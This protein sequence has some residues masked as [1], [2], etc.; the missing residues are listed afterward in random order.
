MKFLPSLTLNEIRH[1]PRG[2]E[3][4]PVTQSF[5]ACFQALAQLRQLNWLQAGFATRPP[6]LHQCF[7][8]LFLPGLMPTAGRLAVNPQSPSDFPLMEALVK[9]TGGF[10]PSPFEL[11]K[12]TF[13]AFWIAHA[14]ILA[15]RAAI[16][17]ILCEHQ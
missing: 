16:V 9:K 8:S 2:P 13:N 11:F 1:A 10:K 14:G 15:R 5:G 3:G 17:T 4:G 7:G 6:R 12:I